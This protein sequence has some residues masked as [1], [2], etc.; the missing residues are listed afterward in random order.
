MLRT[1]YEPWRL[2]FEKWVQLRRHGNRCLLDHCHVRAVELKPWTIKKAKLGWDRVFLVYQEKWVKNK[3]KK[4]K[5]YLL[6]TQLPMWKHK[7][8]MKTSNACQVP[9]QIFKRMSKG[10]V[11][12]T[13]IIVS[14]TAFGVFSAID[15]FRHL[16]RQE[17]VKFDA[18]FRILLNI[19][20]WNC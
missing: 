20:F 19:F 3:K 1:S 9:S 18:A 4:N 6:R 12:N 15:T 11:R 10:W 16:V 8:N 7:E 2:G 5:L 17:Q 13:Q 14:M